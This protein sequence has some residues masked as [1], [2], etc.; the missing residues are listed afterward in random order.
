[1]TDAARQ[2]V[3]E[4]VRAAALAARDAGDLPTFLGELERL[5]VEILL[6]PTNS[7]DP[8]RDNDRLLSVAEVA[9]RIGRSQWWVYANKGSLP[10]VRLPTGRYAFS[11]KRLERWIQRRAAS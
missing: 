6:P 8:P 2:A 10:I 3:L 5:R 7:S 1:M 4:S 9:Q 11:E